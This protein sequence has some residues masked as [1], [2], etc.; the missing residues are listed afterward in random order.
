[1]AVVAMGAGLRDRKRDNR[2]AV[3]PPKTRSRDVVAGRDAHHDTG[4][5]TTGMGVAAARRTFVPNQGR[6]HQTWREARCGNSRR[7]SGSEKLALACNDDDI[8]L[9]QTKINAG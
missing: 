8:R 1:V 9:A 2:A 6:L 4:A 5:Q 7:A 3:R